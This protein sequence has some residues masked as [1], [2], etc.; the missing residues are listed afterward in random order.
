[1]ADNAPKILKVY[2][3]N[4]PH[5]EEHDS[6]NFSNLQALK[7]IKS[8]EASQIGRKGTL[9]FLICGDKSVLSLCYGIGGI[10]KH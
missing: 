5:P 9:L 4:T 6:R 10:R 8:P 3:Y 7:Q 2:K 1:L